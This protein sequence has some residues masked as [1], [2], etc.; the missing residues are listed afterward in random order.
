MIGSTERIIQETVSSTCLKD[1]LTTTLLKHNDILDQGSDLM[2]SRLHIPSR[3]THAACVKRCRLPCR[4]TY[5]FGQERLNLSSPTSLGYKTLH[6]GEGI[7]WQRNRPA[8]KGF[9][10]K[11]QYTAT[12]LFNHRP[13]CFKTRKM[14][15]PLLIKTKTFTKSIFCCILLLC[16]ISLDGHLHIDLL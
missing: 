3:E 6:W 7:G 9:L 4:T 10:W 11:T 16:S 2:L 15:T 1:S 8:V 14:I 13:I 5:W 12:A